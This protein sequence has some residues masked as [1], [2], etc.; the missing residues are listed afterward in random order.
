MRFAS[1]LAYKAV[2]GGQHVHVHTENA[3]HLQSVDQLM[4]EY[5]EHQFIPHTSSD[6]EQQNLPVVIGFEQPLNHFDQIL[7]N[8]NAGVPAFFGRFDRV[9]EIIVDSIKVQGRDKYKYY[10]DRGYPLFHHQMDDW[11]D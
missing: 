5:P 2:S 7:I 10:R 6:S 11:N 8:L 4:W 1:R 9:I 3:K